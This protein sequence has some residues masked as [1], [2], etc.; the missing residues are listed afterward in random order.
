MRACESSFT[1]KDSID[2]A[3]SIALGRRNTG[4]PN[5]TIC[6][7][8]HALP[9]LI[10]RA[11]LSKLRF[12]NCYVRFVWYHNTTHAGTYDGSF[13]RSNSVLQ[14]TFDAI[15]THVEDSFDLSQSD[16][17]NLRSPKIAVLALAKIQG[18]TEAELLIHSKPARAQFKGLNMGCTLIG[19]KRIRLFHRLLHEEERFSGQENDPNVI[20]SIMINSLL[21]YP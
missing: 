8:I 4:I 7:E 11:T 5:L 3:N 21:P 16:L 9:V 15:M 19:R 2:L 1:L 12:E 6:T 13:I 18:R 10:Y 14:P 20:T 17:S